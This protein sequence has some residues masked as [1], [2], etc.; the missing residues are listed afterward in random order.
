MLTL[1]TVL[2]SLGVLRSGASALQLWIAASPQR[3]VAW[4]F[5]DEDDASCQGLRLYG[6]SG[7]AFGALMAGTGLVFTIVGAKRHRDHRE[8]E[9]RWGGTAF[10]PKRGAGLALHLRW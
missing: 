5:G 2:L 8:W 10:F 7:L 9:R 6:Y 1:G 3:C 4:G